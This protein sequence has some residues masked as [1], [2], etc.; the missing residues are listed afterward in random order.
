MIQCNST[1]TFKLGDR[2]RF[3]KEAIDRK[4]YEYYRNERAKKIGTV[5]GFSREKHPRVH[6]D[7]MSEHTNYT[8]HPNFV[9]RILNEGDKSV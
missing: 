3:S 6:W 9:E 2:V 8:Y 4:I 5:I 1:K 7:G